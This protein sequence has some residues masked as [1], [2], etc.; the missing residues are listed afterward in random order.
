MEKTFEKDAQYISIVQ[1]ILDTKEFDDMKHIRH[2][3]NN[4]LDHCIKVSYYSYKI[5]KALHV[6][7]IDVA[8]AGLLHDF[9]VERTVDYNKM[10]DK[11]L[12][13]T[14]KH[15]LEAVENSKKLFTINAKQEDIIKCHMFPMD[16]RIPKYVESWIV[17]LVDTGLSI[18]EFSKKFSYKLSYITNLLLIVL[19][20]TIK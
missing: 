1:D 4:R 14:T 17:N 9:F 15:P 2:H 10:K 13:F 3:D 11:F 7:Y 8:R 20:N 19:L 16:Y 18:N 5:A 12:L 6:D